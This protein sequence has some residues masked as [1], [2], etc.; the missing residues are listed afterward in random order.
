MDAS[1]VYLLKL[2]R[3]DAKHLHMTNK[4]IRSILNCRISAP[5]QYSLIPWEEFIEIPLDGLCW[6]D[7]EVDL[8]GAD[9][10]DLLELL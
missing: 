9:D 10:G 5:S 6:Y 4:Y 2:A 8:V 3:M 1:L 7:D